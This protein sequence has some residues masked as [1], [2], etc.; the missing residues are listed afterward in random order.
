M[1]RHCFHCR[2]QSNCYCCDSVTM[3][4]TLVCDDD[5]DD[6]EV[7]D[8]GVVRFCCLFLFAVVWFRSD[9]ASSRERPFAR[10]NQGAA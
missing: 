1:T 5:V 3:V 4:H 6:E 9:S 7:E 8:D 10:A 2:H